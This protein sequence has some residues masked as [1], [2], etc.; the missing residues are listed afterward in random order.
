[1][2]K[3]L[4]Q[5]EFIRRARE[6]HGDRYD[7]SKVEYVNAR[8]K[9]CIV[10][11]RHNEFWQTPRD[12]L[13][14]YG[15]KTCG[16]EVISDSKRMTLHC[17]LDKAN[18]IHNS[19]Y[20]YSK[21]E[22]I[23]TENKV[24]I[25]CPEHG[26]F[27]QTPHR[28]LSGQGCPLCG[29]HKNTI[30]GVGTNDVNECVKKSNLTLCYAAWASMLRR[31][32]NESVLKQNPTYKGCSVCEE[33]HKFS[34]FRAW[35]DERHVEGWHLDKDILVKGNKVYSPETCCFVPREINNLF[36][37]K[38]R[39]RGPYPI[40]V[41]MAFGRMKAKI[42]RHGKYVSL[43]YFDTP[44]EAFCAYKEAKETYIREVADIWKNKLDPRVYEALYNYKVEI[45]D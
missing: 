44:E 4:T 36:V 20:N 21:V 41:S 29:R 31:C 28:H 9:V 30:E 10:C 34:S 40:G 11:P 7:Y 27:W 38:T 1:M 43:G 32:Y 3:K 35:W 13:S 5:E 33:W 45:T 12:H 14:G 22:Y 42:S 37:K 6:L 26:E 17:F 2:A 16:L 23:G 24:C 15:C 19:K 25:I 39:C 8:T 18:E